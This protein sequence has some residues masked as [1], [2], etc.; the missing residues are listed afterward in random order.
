MDLFDVITYRLGL[1]CVDGAGL[2]I[3]SLRDLQSFELCVG[4]TFMSS[5]CN[6]NQQM[7]IKP[8]TVYNKTLKSVQITTDLRE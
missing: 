2:C 3:S 5:N 8:Y 1:L 6:T 4:G 7:L